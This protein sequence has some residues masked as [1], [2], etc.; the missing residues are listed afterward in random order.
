[1]LGTVVP[2]DLAIPDTDMALALTA[3][4][5][6]M[7]QLPTELTDTPIPLTAATDTVTSVMLR[8]SQRL[9]LT[10]EAITDTAH[11]LMEDMDTD[12]VPMAM[13]PTDTPAHTP[14]AAT[15]IRRRMP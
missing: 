12:T 7:P 9:M 11:T 14:M 15:T 13:V 10:T 3:L 6:P 2:M 4:M 8:P 1:M 5:E